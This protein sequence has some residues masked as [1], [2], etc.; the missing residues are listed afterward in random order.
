MGLVD[1]QWGYGNGNVMD[2]ATYNYG[3]PWHST[4]TYSYA[5][6]SQAVKLPSQAV[7]Q[8]HTVVTSPSTSTTVQRA[9]TPST[10]GTPTQGQTSTDAPTRPTAMEATTNPMTPTSPTTSPLSLAVET[11]P[12]SLAVETTSSP[13]SDRGVTR[14][15]GA[16]FGVSTSSPAITVASSSSTAAQLIPTG[17]SGIA[18][19]EAPAAGGIGKGEIAGIVL[20]IMFALGLGCVFYK[21][22]RRKAAQRPERESFIQYRTPSSVIRSRRET[23][24]AGSQRSPRMQP[25]LVRLG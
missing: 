22:W 12:L 5:Y 23:Y 20:A 8:T 4:S 18:N 16:T 25:E 3:D 21:V 24:L 10:T 2:T 11:S 13:A 7:A 6:N 19:S 9:T 1:R 17:P 14:S 15:S